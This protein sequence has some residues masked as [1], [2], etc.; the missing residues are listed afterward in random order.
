MQAASVSMLCIIHSVLTRP[1]P[2]PH[3]TLAAAGS[4]HVSCCRS[5]KGMCAHEMALKSM[6]NDEFL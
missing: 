4:Y 3:E 5:A 2:V 6:C 1:L